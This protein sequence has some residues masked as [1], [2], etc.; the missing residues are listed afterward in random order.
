[1]KVPAGGT[2]R[3]ALIARSAFTSTARPAV[4]TSDATAM[5]GLHTS[6]QLVGGGYVTS[7]SAEPCPALQFDFRAPRYDLGNPSTLDK[8]SGYSARSMVLKHLELDS[9]TA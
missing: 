9:A 6:L 8:L 5:F 3:C 4:T 7:L 1:M 2:H